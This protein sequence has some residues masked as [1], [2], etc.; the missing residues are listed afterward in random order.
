MTIRLWSFGCLALLLWASHAYSQDM[1][2]IGSVAFVVP[3]GWV[4]LKKESDVSFYKAEKGH[5][6][7]T[8]SS[9]R[10]PKPISFEKF[11]KLCDGEIDIAQHGD[12]GV[13]IQKKTAFHDRKIFRCF[14]S[15]EN[16]GPK[17]ISSGYFALRDNE[18]ISINLSTYYFS[19][20]SVNPKEHLAI[21]ETWAS[22]VFPNGGAKQ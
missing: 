11:E 10:F 1:D 7:A 8:L 21:L 20:D 5:Q 14:F 16:D 4:R 3:T 22:E 13:F 15:V 2:V 6:Q 18:L 17:R 12:K 19:G 9:Y